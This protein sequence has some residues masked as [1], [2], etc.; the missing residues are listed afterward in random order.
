[1]RI[2]PCLAL[3]LLAMLVASEATAQ[4]QSASPAPTLL[5]N[6]RLASV[7]DL[8]LFFRLYRVHLPAAQR[9]GY[10]GAS[11]M[12]YDLSGEA[13][14]D[15][16]GGPT[17]SLAEGAGAYIAA[18]QDVTISAAK[19]GP[20]ELLLFVLT[21][22][23]NER[24]PLFERPAS[25]VELFRTPEPLQGL[26]DGPYEFSLSR[27]TLPAATPASPAGYRSGAALD[28]VLAG[29][30]ALIADGKTQAVP[31]ETPLVEGYRWV[32]QW[33]NP[34]ETPLVL[35]QANISREGDAAVVPAGAK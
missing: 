14:I 6:G 16:G 1:M 18:G 23:P 24:R 10:E 33:A 27:V 25:S 22:R 28:Y 34:D 4:P 13:A 20:A 32:H 2:N 9:A 3:A 7:V 26:T 8:P 15:I 17:Q 21:A 29:A 35:L 5:A 30:G 11:T 31:A 12:L 19:T